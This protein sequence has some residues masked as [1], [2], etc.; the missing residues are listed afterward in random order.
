MLTLW[1]VAALPR[2]E[3]EEGGLFLAATDRQ[4]A[5]ISNDDLMVVLV[6]GQSLHGTG[7]TAQYRQKCLMRRRKK[8]M[9]GH[10]C[11]YLPYIPPCLVAAQAHVGMGTVTV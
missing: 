10:C 2:D 7:A 9:H 5:Q 8:H 6:V 4:A 11:R 1:E 3:E